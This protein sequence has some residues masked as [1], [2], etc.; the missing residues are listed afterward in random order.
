[1]L[2][3]FGCTEA[4]FRLSDISR[5]IG[6]FKNVPEHRQLHTAMAMKLLP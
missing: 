1:M 5:L 4:F 2:T 6:H 3:G